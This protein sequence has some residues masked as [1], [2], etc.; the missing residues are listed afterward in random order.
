MEVRSC[1]PVQVWDAPTRIFHWLN[2]LTVI[3]ILF[4]GLAF[5]FRGFLNLDGHEA[6]LVFETAM[7]KMHSVIGYIF[8]ANLIFR[9]I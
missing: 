1:Q 3:L 8:M 2:V 5:T 4:T 9:L 6:S 7:I